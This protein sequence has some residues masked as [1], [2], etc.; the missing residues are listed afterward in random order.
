MATITFYNDGKVGMLD[1]SMDLNTDTF[2][3]TL[4]T[5]TYTPD[6]DNDTTTAD[7]SNELAAS[8]NY[9]TGGQALDNPTV[10][11]DDTNNRAVW[12]ADNETWSALTASAAFRYGVINNVTDSNS[13][14]CYIDF[15]SDQQPG[16]SDFTVQ[17]HADGIGYI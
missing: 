5:S 11:A 15:I 9:A 2:N 1:G 17:F 13:L 16:G 8:G 7:L 12:D 10:T 14:V 6:I 4:H 3:L